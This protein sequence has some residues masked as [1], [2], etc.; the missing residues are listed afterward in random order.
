MDVDDSRISTDEKNKTIFSLR[1]LTYLLLLI[2]CFKNR[3]P[4]PMS[5]NIN[6]IV[7]FRWNIHQR[8]ILEM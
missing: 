5:S 4:F 7:R 3:N 1:V 8:S 6:H 2:S